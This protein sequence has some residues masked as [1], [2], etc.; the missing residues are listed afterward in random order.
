V[1]A[2][3]KAEAPAGR[4]VVVTTEHR[5][6]FFGLLDGAPGETVTIRQ[7]RCCLYWSTDVRG[8][9]GLA[10]KGPSEDCRVGPPAPSLTLF[11]VTSVVE[12]APE[13]AEAWEAAPWA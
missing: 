2:K 3:K 10:A 13:A 6:V 7:A 11:K 12:V 8:F 1:S 5:G 4:W 9:L